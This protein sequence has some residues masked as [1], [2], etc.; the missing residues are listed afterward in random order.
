MVR[1]ELDEV[2]AESFKAWRRYQES[3]EALL[4][5]GVFEIKKGIAQLTFSPHG[6]LISV[7]IEAESWRR[8]KRK[9][10]STA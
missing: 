7:K 4:E 9:G 3:F 8:K 2:E 1:I 6:K 10:L 5:A